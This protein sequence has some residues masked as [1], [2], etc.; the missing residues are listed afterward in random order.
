MQIAVLSD[1]HLGVKDG[2]DR[3]G[4][5][6][7]AEDAFVSLLER[8]ENS[9]D[10]I[11]LLG[12]I[13]ETLRGAAPGSKKSELMKALAC[14]PRIAKRALEDRRYQ[15]I[16]GNHDAIVTRALGTPDLH[17]IDDD[18]LR[19]AFF[20]GHQLDPI[21]RGH[22][23]LSRIAVWLGGWL[24]RIG[25]PITAWEDWLHRAELDVNQDG[26]VHEPDRFA[27]AAVA[28]A[29]E[30]QKADVVIT[31]HTH[32]AMRTEIAGS[33]FMNSGTCTG[34][35]LEHLIIDTTTKRFDIHRG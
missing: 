15:L 7:G 29:N 34:G 6:D 28:F 4:R 24:E 23:P 13:F 33:M 25:L 16:Q 8:L 19:L 35:R 18:G 10:K 32:R 27:R 31:G 5:H 12:D 2:L 22:A 20:H 1:L 17:V 9:V 11:I 21:A 3:F 26:L 14:Y 30:H